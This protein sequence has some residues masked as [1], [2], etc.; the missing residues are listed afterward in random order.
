[1]SLVDAHMSTF[2]S[3]TILSPIFKIRD[4]LSASM[5]PSPLKPVKRKSTLHTVNGSKIVKHEVVRPPVVSKATVIPT[6]RNDRRV[7]QPLSPEEPP[8]SAAKTTRTKR[9]H[10]NDESD[11][12]A[13]GALIPEG[14]KIDLGI[15]M[16]IKAP[17]HV[18]INH[19]EHIGWTQSE[20]DLFNRLN[21]RGAV[22]ILPHS[23]Q[24]DFPTMPDNLF[25]SNL[26]EVYIK[27]SEGTDF[28]GLSCLSEYF[29]LS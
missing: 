15:D 25:S 24:L 21:D 6:P 16:T 17:E 23:W 2:C 28:R 22:P 19:P 7:R 1:M 5:S 29:S 8:P 9:L 10:K 11:D 20:V 27:P 26:D 12:D 13:A 3:S 14:D 18:T 4:R